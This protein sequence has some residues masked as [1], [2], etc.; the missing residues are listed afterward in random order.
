MLELNKIY[1]MD[2]LD[3]MKL[4]DDNSMDSIVTD[5]PYELGFMG[6]KWDSTGIAYNVDVW[7]ECLRVLK[8]G[9]HLLA[10]GGTR[11]YHRMACA[12]EDAGFE[13]RD[14]I[15]WLYG[16]GFPKSHDISKAI[17]KKLGVEREIINSYTRKGRSGGIMGEKVE[18][19]RNI[20]APAT[21]EAQEWDGWGTALK[22]ANEPIVLARKP[23]SEKTIAENVMKWGT[24]GLNIDGCRIEMS[25]EDF[26]AYV[27]KEKSFYKARQGK[28]IYGGNSLFES[29]TK[30]ANRIE[31]KGRF[32]ANVILDEEAAALLDEQSGISKP[33]KG[34]TG[35]R[36]GTAWHGQKG[37]G[38]PDKIGRWP[39]DSGGGASR[40]FYCAKASKKERG[41]G[42]NHPTVKPV[43]LMEY[44]ITLITPPNG[45]VL[46]PFFGSGTTGV[47]AV[48]LGF[49][50]IGFE[51]DKTYYNIAINRINA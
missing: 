38:S 12:I 8:P 49:N 19:E 43:K 34:R 20:T 26:E 50:Y 14:Q 27:R 5:P 48:K 42:N 18:I 17:D 10:F 37:L 6:K 2:C 21:P 40:F 9:G 22:P 45:I 13:I 29:K 7:R 31:T 46:D 3:G 1:N 24:G 23:I 16:S 36:G 41:E 30:H 32:P 11:T 35:K 47:A 44:L 51:L 15:Q 28:N 4:L 33:R 39:S 25:P